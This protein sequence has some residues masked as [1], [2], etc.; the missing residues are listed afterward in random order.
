M[1]SMLDISALQSIMKKMISVFYSSGGMHSLSTVF[2]WIGIGILL[3]LGI[4]YLIAHA[5]TIVEKLSNMTV[6]QFITMMALMGVAFIVL[7]IV[8]P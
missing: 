3:A 7:A 2:A 1:L 8:L 6:R 4:G 5:R